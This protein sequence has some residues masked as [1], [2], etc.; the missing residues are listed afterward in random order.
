MPIFHPQ[1]ISIAWVYMEAGSECMGCM[2]GSEGTVWE[3]FMGGYMEVCT[4]F[5]VVCMA[6]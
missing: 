5:T 3:D 2:E 1:G 4:V 6:E